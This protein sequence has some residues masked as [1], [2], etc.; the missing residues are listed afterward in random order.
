MPFDSSQ[1][2]QSRM[3]GSN[4]LS[5]IKVSCCN[6]VQDIDYN[7][8]QKLCS[9]FFLVILLVENIFFCNEKC[10]FY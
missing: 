1:D 2:E 8:Y 5:I 7:N 4:L 9:R 6:Q 3:N 10:F